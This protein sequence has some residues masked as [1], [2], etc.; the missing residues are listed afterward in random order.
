ML[1]GS[2]GLTADDP[3]K[4]IAVGPGCIAAASFRNKVFG[5][6]YFDDESGYLRVLEDMTECESPNTI[7]QRKTVTFDYIQ[8]V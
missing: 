6:V 8:Y 1:S 5:A 4:D 7:I 2:P 3:A